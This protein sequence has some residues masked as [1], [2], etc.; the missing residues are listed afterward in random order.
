M[1]SRWRVPRLD[2]EDR[3]TEDGAVRRF[4]LCRAKCG[5]YGGHCGYY[6]A[7]KLW[8]K[9]GKYW[10]CKADWQRAFKEGGQGF[11]AMVAAY[12]PNAAQWPSIGCGAK[13]APWRRGESIV[14]EWR[15]SA[16][17]GGAETYDAML[18]DLLP[19]ML[20][21]EVKRDQARLLQK[22]GEEFGVFGNFWISQAT[23][24]RPLQDISARLFPCLPF[25]SLDPSPSPSGPPPPSPSVSPPPPS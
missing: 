13:F 5:G 3:L 10:Y 24:R 12:G 17:G 16:A 7:S 2:Y 22:G 18:A 1:V 23:N 6:Y 19:E 21:I 9:Q 14:L 20:D 8:T 11:E 4:Y 15:T 25:P